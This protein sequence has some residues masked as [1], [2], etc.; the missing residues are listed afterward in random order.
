M[1]KLAAVADIQL[2][3]APLL[4]LFVTAMT[5][6]AVTSARG[7]PLVNSG[8]RVTSSELVFIVCFWGMVVVGVALIGLG[9]ARP[10]QA[11]REA[12]PARL[13]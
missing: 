9:L 7:G 12:R 13:A 3:L 5:M 1:L 11:S 10:R 4:P 8:S 6:I 2:S